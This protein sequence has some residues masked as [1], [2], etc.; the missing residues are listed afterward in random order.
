LLGVFIR[1]SRMFFTSRSFSVPFS[2]CTRANM[3][4]DSLYRV[5]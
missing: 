5:Q 4:F 2:A 1:F 3:L